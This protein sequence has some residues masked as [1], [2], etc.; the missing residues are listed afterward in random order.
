M[1][2]K[3]TD[4]IRTLYW[5]SAYINAHLQASLQE[6][7]KKYQDTPLYRAL[8]M[9]GLSLVETHYNSYKKYVKDKANVGKA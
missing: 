5:V 6:V 1:A 3:I 9:K 7:Q 8:T 2:G 4:E